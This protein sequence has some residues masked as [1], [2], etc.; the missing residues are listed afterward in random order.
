[1]LQMQVPVITKPNGE[2]DRDAIIE[3]VTRRLSALRMALMGSHCETTTSPVVSKADQEAAELGELLC[4]TPTRKGGP[5]RKADPNSARQRVF[6]SLREVLAEG[7]MEK[8][9]VLQAVSERTGL[10]LAT[11]TVNA[12][13]AP[14]IRR[15]YG[16]WSL[17]D[18]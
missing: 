15:N 17:K 9:K 1:M 3:N 11:C 10:N 16:L 8:H 14:G 7:Q 4:P 13:A 12:D 6:T 2:P 5:G 18:G